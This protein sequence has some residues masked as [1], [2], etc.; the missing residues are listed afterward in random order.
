MPSRR[1]LIRLGCA[2]AATLAMR[3]F[4]L[5]TAMAGTTAASSGDYKALVC[6]FLYGGNDGNNM[7]VPATGSAFASYTSIRGTI[8]LPASSLLPV[9]GPSGLE[10]GLHPSLK[11]LQALYGSNQVALALNVGPLI[12]PLTKAQYAGNSA[13]TPSNLFS[14]ADQQREWQTS[15]LNGN[16]TSGW[17]GRVADLVSP[18]N[19]P[20]TYP[21][22]VSVAGN[23]MQGTGAQTRAATVNPGAPLGLQARNAEIPS[24]VE[25][26]LTATSGVTLVQAA[27][28]TLSNGQND[29]TTL[30]AALAGGKAL[31]TQF[32]KS[33]LGAQL[34]QVANIIAVRNE[35]GM[36]RQ[37][38]FCALG[39]FDTHAGQLS[40]QSK[41][42]AELSQGL[43]AF[44]EATQEMGVASQVTAFTESDFGRTLSPT[45]NGGSDHAWGNHHI[46]IGGAVKGGEMYGAFPTLE[47]GGPDDTDTRGR[48]IPTA[49]VDQYGAT[50]AAWFGVDAASLPGAFPNLKN[51]ASQNLGF[52]G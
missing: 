9:G 16:P 45:S 35:M 52:L 43:N 15:I 10:F 46:V 40:T 33:V 31:T 5:I 12:Q 42:L 26:L 17:G 39:N 36:K 2:T 1:S 21:A 25:R 29:A 8:A 4:G 44:Y 49:S 22:F 47:L 30:S 24:G 7:V 6:V 34:E 27:A 51:F 3:R 23:T 28:S 11:E 19:A 18:M 32:P 41:L 13:P 38:F 48:W 37:I 20:A 50:L 14:H